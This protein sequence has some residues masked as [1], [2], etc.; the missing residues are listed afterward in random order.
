MKIHTK[1]LRE[2]KNDYLGG[3]GEDFIEV[4]AWK[5]ALGM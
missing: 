2:V 3:D 4:E 1:Q 5:W